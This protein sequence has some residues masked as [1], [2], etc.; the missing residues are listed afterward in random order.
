MPIKSNNT[1]GN[2]YHDESTGEFTSPDAASTAN[3]NINTIVGEKA[4]KLKNGVTV[5]QIQQDLEKTKGLKKL[6][7]EGNAII[8]SKSHIVGYDPTTDIE[9]AKMF[10]LALKQV[11]DMFPRLFDNELLLA[12]GTRAKSTATKQDKT[13]AWKKV[14]SQE[15]FKSKFDS[16]GLDISSLQGVLNLTEN[17]NN[18]FNS[19]PLPPD[20]GGL[21]RSYGAALFGNQQMFH[22]SSVKLNETHSK[23]MDDWYNYAKSGEKNGSFLAV[24]DKSNCPLAV[25]AHELGHHV[26]GALKT[27]LD[28]NDKDALQ[29]M[30]YEGAKLFVTEKKKI[31]RYAMTDLDEFI[32]ESFFDYFANGEEHATPL[33]TSVVKYLKGVYDKHFV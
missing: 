28:S 7:D 1:Y 20:V 10:N 13:E 30:Q 18:D 9:V 14:I 29:K 15:P 3:A 26:Y 16:Y 11:H 12:Y 27:F 32:S 24:S 33:N 6:E 5:E 17:N 21:T 4:I 31:S 2:P 25:A 19:G 22:V 23:S 8:G